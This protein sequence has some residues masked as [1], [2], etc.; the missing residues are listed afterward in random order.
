M[1]AE[2]ILTQATERRAALGSTVAEYAGHAETDMQ[3]LYTLL[4]EAQGDLERVTAERDSIQKE[5]DKVPMLEEELRNTQDELKDAN[6]K[7]GP[8]DE[9]DELKGRIAQLEQESAEH[10]A[11]LTERDATIQAL[12]EEIAVFRKKNASA[13][14]GINKVI[15]LIIGTS[16]FAE[17]PTSVRSTLHDLGHHTTVTVRFTKKDLLGMYAIIPVERSVERSVERPGGASGGTS[18][19]ARGGGKKSGG[20][21]SEGGFWMTEEPCPM[22]RDMHGSRVHIEHPAMMHLCTCDRSAERAVDSDAV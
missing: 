3:A 4:M 17:P 19:G 13:R 10:V 1:Y 2:N 18:G 22:F 12:K 20:K 11:Q 5:A 8:L 14:H 15:T 21:K 7:L 16:A 6:A 9:L